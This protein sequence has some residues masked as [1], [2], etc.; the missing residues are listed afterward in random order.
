MSDWQ[1]WI[2]AGVGLLIAEMIAPGFWLINV[3]VGC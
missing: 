3:A 2:I 1:L